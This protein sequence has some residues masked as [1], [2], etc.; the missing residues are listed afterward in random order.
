M[1]N[2][3]GRHARAGRLGDALQDAAKVAKL[4]ETEE[5]PNAQVSTFRSVSE[6]YFHVKTFSNNSL[7][8]CIPMNLT[9][10]T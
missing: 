7:Q 8:L 10:L 3:A 9:F 5:K 6:F 2:L 1:I 4:L